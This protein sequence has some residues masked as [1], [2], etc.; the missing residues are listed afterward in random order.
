MSVRNFVNVDLIPR[1]ALFKSVATGRKS[2]TPFFADLQRM[3]SLA[4]T[5]MLK[6][7]ANLLFEPDDSK[8]PQLVKKRGRPPKIPRS[9]EDEE[10]A[11]ATPDSSP[12]LSK[13]SF[14]V[15]HHV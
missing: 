12:G 9:S 3:K 2:V 4:G 6:Q 7:P 11:D 14:K 1:P 13:H 8:P 5:E 10:A 15:R